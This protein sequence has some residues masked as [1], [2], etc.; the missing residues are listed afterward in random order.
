MTFNLSRIIHLEQ[1]ESDLSFVLCL[2]LAV[3]SLLLLEHRQASLLLLF[4]VPMP[5]FLANPLILRSLRR[6]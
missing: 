3:V 1:M 5:C 6:S 2:V 4:L